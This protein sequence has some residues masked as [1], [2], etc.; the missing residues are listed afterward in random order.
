MKKKILAFLMSAAVALS[1]FGGVTTQTI[2]QETTTQTVAEELATS[3]VASVKKIG[4]SLATSDSSSSVSKG[5]TVYNT[6]WDKY[7]NNYAYN[8]LSSSKKKI[9]DKLDKACRK[10]LTSTKDATYYSSAGIYGTDIV[11]GK[12]MSDT[13]M[14]NL[15]IQFKYSNPQ[16]YFINGSFLG[17]YYS[18]G[19]AIVLQ[20]YDSFADGSDRKSVSK[21]LKS[22]LDSVIKKAKSK[23]SSASK[24]VKYFHDYI[25][26]RVSYLDDA[27]SGND[28]GD[29]YY[30]TQ[31]AYSALLGSK[32]VCA[33]YSLA[34][35][36]LCNGAG[37]DCMAVTSEVHAW[38]KIRLNDSWYNIDL[39]WDDD[40]AGYLYYLR[41]SS[42]MES[43][44][45]GYAYYHD[46]ESA[47]GSR[48]PKCTLDSGSTQSTA[49]SAKSIS[50]KVTTPKIKVKISGSKY[51]VT[52]SCATSGA[53]I[54]YTTD[55]KTPDCSSSISK[56][57]KKSFKLTKAKLK[58]L[59]VIAVKNKY[60]DSSV[61]KFKKTMLPIK[62]KYNV[63]GGK[64]S[65]KK[66]FTAYA[67]KKVGTLKTPTRKGYTFKG[68]YTKKSGGKKV[69]KK[70]KLKKNTTLYAH[71]KKK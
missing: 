25:A 61:K 42:K 69:T 30:Y 62:V 13:D 46:I 8:K 29:A 68:W 57:Y 14:K 34:L 19:Y 26:N 54:Y 67:Y 49:K 51:K 63:N 31:S 43:L 17:T 44:D 33:G 28:Y 32:S 4:G 71:W 52:L 16:Y 15:L 58:K 53:T 39:T 36:M 5:S 22:R 40:G 64:L 41:S 47:W 20:V 1:T 37:I 18:G 21:K 70:T 59:K 55:G 48:S 9:W 23:Y 7:S 38:N 2:A 60:K 66:S 45:G 27:S 65:G 10:L 12:G 6:S 11:K 35:E 50:N 24:R 3:Q 56:V